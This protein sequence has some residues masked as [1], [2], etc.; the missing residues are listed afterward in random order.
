VS[1]RTLERLF[2]H[3]PRPLADYIRHHRLEAVRRDLSDPLL[4]HLGIGVI[5][6]RWCLFDPAHLSRLHRAQY[7][8]TPS[9]ARYAPS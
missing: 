2:A 5:A 8:M 1:S 9:Q 3:E 4:M 7:G 6:A